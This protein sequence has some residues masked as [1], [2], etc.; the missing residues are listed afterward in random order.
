MPN[1]NTE[2]TERRN[3]ILE[4]LSQG[5]VGTQRD[6]V[7][8]LSSRG[9]A[10]TQ[11]SINR[12]LKDLSM[13]EIAVLLLLVIPILWIGVYPASF[14][15]KSESAIVRL[16]ERIDEKSASAWRAGK[17]VEPDRLLAGRAKRSGEGL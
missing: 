5:P 10:V 3:A 4:L 7:A 9:L 12:D 6:L 2:Q 8:E 1:N 11:S 17:T 13:R 16:L 15:S 14:T